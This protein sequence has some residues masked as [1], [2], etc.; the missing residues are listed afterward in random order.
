MQRSRLAGYDEQKI[1]P[2]VG[3]RPLQSMAV[4]NSRKGPAPEQRQVRRVSFVS[5]KHPHTAS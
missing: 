4:T 3:L 2:L 5:P 1:R